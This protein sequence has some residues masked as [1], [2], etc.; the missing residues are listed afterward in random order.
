MFIKYNAAY[1]HITHLATLEYETQWSA[2]YSV[3]KNLTAGH[4]ECS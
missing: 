4:L 3:V 1:P 2:I